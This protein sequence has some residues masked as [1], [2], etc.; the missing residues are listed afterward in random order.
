[1]PVEHSGVRRGAEVGAYAIRRSRQ[2]DNAGPM[3][4]SNFVRYLLLPARLAGDRSGAQTLLLD[5]DRHF[6]GDIAQ[7]QAAAL[8]QELRRG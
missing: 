1:M 4:T 2:A 8:A 6:P 5:F 3:P 7:P